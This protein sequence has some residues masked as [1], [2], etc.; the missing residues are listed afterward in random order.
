MTNALSLLMPLI[1]FV[2]VGLAV[3]TV[4]VLLLR[5]RSA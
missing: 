5:K 4:V 1:V 2:G 3:G